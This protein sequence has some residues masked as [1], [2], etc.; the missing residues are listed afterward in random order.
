M[1]AKI[2]ILAILLTQICFAIPEQSLITINKT[3]FKNTSLETYFSSS[4]LVE[5]SKQNKANVLRLKAGVDLSQKWSSTFKFDLNANFSLESGRTDSLYDNSHWEPSNDFSSNRAEFVWQP[6]KMIELKAGA[7]NLKDLDSRLLLRRTAFLGTKETLQY[8]ND[9]LSIGVYGLQT[10]P[11]N[12]NYSNR[13]DE[14][15]EGMPVFYMEGITLDYHSQRFR[16]KGHIS[17]FAYD[18]LSNSVAGASIFHGNS[19]NRTDDKNGEFVY[20]YIGTTSA[21]QVDLTISHFTFSTRADYVIN[22]SAPSDNEAYSFGFQS[23]FNYND[24]NYSIELE[25]FRSEADASVA[26]YNSTWYGHNNSYGQGMTFEIENEQMQTKYSLSFRR[27]KEIVPNQRTETETDD[28]ISF[29]LRKAYE[30]F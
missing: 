3:Q 16:F 15:D 2:F 6:L 19:V 26:Y 27:A 13:L 5:D 30:I 17:K 1:K 18:N 12:R 4:Y 9:T 24:V 20:S 28:L 14:V 25:N 22:E 21:A 10:I 8:S 29:K 11:N 7:I 23:L